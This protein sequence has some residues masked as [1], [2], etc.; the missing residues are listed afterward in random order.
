MGGKPRALPAGIGIWPP[1]GPQNY[2]NGQ[3]GIT[4]GDCFAWLSTHYAD[5]IIH[6][7][8]PVQRNFVLGKFFDLWG[9][10]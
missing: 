7:E 6:T 8:S 4:Q 5:G 2:R 9:N 1:L 10:R 3:F